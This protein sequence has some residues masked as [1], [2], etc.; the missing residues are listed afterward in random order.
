MRKSFKEKIRPEIIISMLSGWSKLLVIVVCLLSL[1]SEIQAKKVHY[2]RYEKIISSEKKI[3]LYIQLTRLDDGTITVQNIGE[4]LR[5]VIESAA[6]HDLCLYDGDSSGLLT[7]TPA[8]SN[9]GAADQKVVDSAPIDTLISHLE[10]IGI[11][12]ANPM[13]A[14][15]LRLISEGTHEVSS[16]SNNPE[17][18][19]P[20]EELI[21]VVRCLR[22][23][24]TGTNLSLVFNN[25]AALELRVVVPE[26]VVRSDM[27]PLFTVLRVR[28]SSENNSLVFRLRQAHR[29]SQPFDLVINDNGSSNV[30]IQGSSSSQFQMIRFSQRPQLCLL[31]DAC[32][33]QDGETY[34]LKKIQ[35]KAKNLLASFHQLITLLGLTVWSELDEYIN[36]D[37]YDL[38]IWFEQFRRYQPGILSYLNELLQQYDSQSWEQDAINEVIDGF[39]ELPMRDYRPNLDSTG[40]DGNQGSEIFNNNESADSGVSRPSANSAP[41]ASR[42]QLHANLLNQAR[43]VTSVADVLS[44]NLESDLLGLLSEFAGAT[45]INQQ[46]Q[47]ATGSTEGLYPANTHRTV[48]SNHEHSS[49]SCP[50]YERSCSVRFACCDQWWPC[51]RC[52]NSKSNC[53]E[54]TLKSFDAQQIKCNLCGEE[55]ALGQY[56]QKCSL[57]FGDYFCS[58][59]KHL[60]GYE[61]N[62]Y[63][64][65]KCGI[66]RRHG[67]RAYHCDTCGICLDR[68]LQGN[69]KCREGTAHEECC[70]CL[71]DSF[72]GCKILRCGHRVHKECLSRWVGAS[73]NG[74]P[75]CRQ[76]LNN[77]R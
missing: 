8:L 53:G 41:G 17:R 2:I 42:A 34:Y 33:V 75:I 15:R 1:A 62:P 47:A 55:Q 67:D 30:H 44:S 70:I 73:T 76:P 58:T 59:C 40:H 61:D 36:N 19:T 24:I 68:S 20:V 46:R 63:H 35:P 16:G 69:H 37:H 51:H 77:R 4:H 49:T 21:D 6:K 72:T 74:C 56:C 5:E 48:R 27:P 10:R 60:T 50:H 66:C 45:G 25:I 9:V 52:H 54:R 18:G 23:M 29:P 71:E 3:N 7:L 64:C 38:R 11:T 26:M 43:R 31:S 12:H 65:D 39:Q 14:S 22:R 57:R 32:E 28:R 13:I